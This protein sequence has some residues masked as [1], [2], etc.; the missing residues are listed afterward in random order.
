MSLEPIKIPQNVYIED[1]IIG[2]ITL[3][4][5]ILLG[6]GGG[7]SYSMW[8]ILAQANG[9]SAPLPLTIIACIPFV[10]SAAFGFVKVNDLSLLR[11]MFLMFERMNKPTTRAFAPR[12]SFSIHI[13]TFDDAAPKKRTVISAEKQQGYQRLDDLTAV[14]DSP[15]E[16]EAASAHIASSD[17]EQELPVRDALSGDG[18]ESKTE[19]SAAATRLPVNRNRI[20]ASPLTEEGKEPVRGS[21]SLFRDIVPK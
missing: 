3:R 13:R 1:R 18:G 12:R 10:I 8:S 19:T 4:Q 21:V 2:P 5:I 15:F 7:I 14:L 20:K 9:G 17:D 16:R 6:I 11:I